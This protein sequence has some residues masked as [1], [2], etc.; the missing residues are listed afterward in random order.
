MT[1]RCDKIQV[2]LSGFSVFPFSPS[3]SG[4][5]HLSHS[6]PAFWCSSCCSVAVQARSS[7]E[8]QV[9]DLLWWH[10]CGHADGGWFLGSPH[11]PEHPCCMGSSGFASCV[12]GGRNGGGACVPLLLQPNPSYRQELLGCTFCYT[13]PVLTAAETPRGMVYGLGGNSTA[14]PEPSCWQISLHWDISQ[15]FS[16]FWGALVCSWD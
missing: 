13:L 3:I 16:V 9:R 15:T 5:P 12:S 11:H 14:S 10:L 4:F 1:C 7:V 8:L 2:V 6:F